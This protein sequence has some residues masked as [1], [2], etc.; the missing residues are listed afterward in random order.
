MAQWLFTEA[1]DFE[2][3]FGAFLS[4]KRERGEEVDA[5]VA[6]IIAKVRRSGN[7]ALIA[8]TEAFDGHRL[9]AGRI[10]LTSADIHDAISACPGEVAQSL[11]F[12]AQRIRAYHERQ[13][14]KDKIYEDA[15]GVLLGHHVLPTGRSARFSSGLGVLD[16]IKRTS[17]LKTRSEALPELGCPAIRLARAEGLEAHARSIAMRLN[18]P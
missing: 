15:A 12:A 14:P 3:K 13:R 4:A 1:A 18:E 8:Y 11:A 16:F 2:S 17:I 10:R 7:N 9:E 6:A 5:A